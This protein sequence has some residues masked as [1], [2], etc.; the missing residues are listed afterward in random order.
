MFDF[1][2][3]YFDDCCSLFSDEMLRVQLVCAV[4][5]ELMKCMAGE[6][7]EAVL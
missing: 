5:V 2:V 3:D 4:L 6:D 1:V 7:L